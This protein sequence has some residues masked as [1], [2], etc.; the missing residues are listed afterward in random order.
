VRFWSISYFRNDLKQLKR[1]AAA[2]YGSCEQDVCR[3]FKEI[4]P[5]TAFIKPQNIRQEGAYLF[6][7]T[8]IPNSQNGLG[9]S[10]GWRII[11]AYNRELNYIVFLH[12]Y[13]KR[14]PYGKTDYSKTELKAILKNFIREA[15]DLVEHD[16][17]NGLTEVNSANVPDKDLQVDEPR[18]EG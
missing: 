2:G 15:D 10:A 17:E 6:K 11:Y 16:I 5:E 13:P 3:E 4:T 9:Q 14:G 8:R 18:P 12:I 1:K 7:K